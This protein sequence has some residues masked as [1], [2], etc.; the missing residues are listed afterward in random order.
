MAIALV[1]TPTT[2]QADDNPE[3]PTGYNTTGANFLVAL[4]VDHSSGGGGTAGDNKG[5][6][7]WVG[8][9]VPTLANSSRTRIYYRTN[10][11]TVG[12]DHRFKF[13]GTGVYSTVVFAAFSGVHATAP[14]VTGEEN[15]AST[16]SS[17]TISAGVV[18]ASTDDS[19][20]I[21]GLGLDIEDNG[22]SI[23][24]S[25]STPVG[26]EKATALTPRGGYMAYRIAVGPLITNPTWTSTDN[27]A[28]TAVMAAFKPAGA[29][30][31]S[32]TNM[33]FPR[34]SSVRR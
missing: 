31:P 20:F 5:N 1:G 17:T 21:T 16:G 23:N 34:W 18:V 24:Q 25:F 14:F 10:S 7:G 19:L 3:T 22:I 2:A 11:P 27:N 13:T 6:T 15:G 30:P 9:T 26:V 12:A 8:L 4:V 29:A 33:I 32:P 28:M